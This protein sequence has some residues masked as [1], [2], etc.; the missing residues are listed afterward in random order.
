MFKLTNP[1]INWE[2]VYT[3][4]KKSYNYSVV[5]TDECKLN[6]LVDSLSSLTNYTMNERMNKYSLHNVF[7]YTTK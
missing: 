5:S 1:Y 3:N 2:R 7:I 4:W 6:L